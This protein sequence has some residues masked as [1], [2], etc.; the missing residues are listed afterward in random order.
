MT[1][2]AFKSMARYYAALSLAL[3]DLDEALVVIALVDQ[4]FLRVRTCAFA[5][6]E[7]SDAPPERRF[8]LL[9]EAL[10]H[11]RTEPDPGLRARELGQIAVRWLDL[12]QRERAVTLLREGQALAEALPAPDEVNLRITGNRGAFA[13]M[14]ARIDG[15]AALPLIEGFSG[16]MLNRFRTDMARGLADHD[17][18]EAERFFRLIDPPGLF[19][20]MRLAPVARMAT[21]DADRAAR[22]AR[23]YRDPCEQAFA[24]GAVAHG[25]RANDREAATDL[26]EEAYGLLDQASQFG[27]TRNRLRNAALTAAALLPVA[28][29]INPDLVE[30]CFW[31]SLSLRQPWP[32]AS[33]A[34]VLRDA[35]LSLLAAMI[36][37]YDR[38]IARDLLAP[39]GDRFGAQFMI[40]P[41][42]TDPR[43]AAEL[44][45][46]MPDVP[47]PLAENPKLIAARNL[48]GWLV[49]PLRGFEGMWEQV[50]G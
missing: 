16:D 15:P 43:W 38:A 7:L 42:V 45:Q 41:G 46:S 48:A 39:L 34:E 14:L 47:A 8:K 1:D 9:D 10:I 25:L 40:G 23:G 12:G 49:R 31:H 20:K 3:T 28:E 29:K 2:P 6:D 50:Y 30:G 11:A 13:G 27:V 24:L 36:A 22:L 33:E 32:A 44:V 21:A 17:P 26:L 19:F 35:G 5:C 18:A 37:R 4:P